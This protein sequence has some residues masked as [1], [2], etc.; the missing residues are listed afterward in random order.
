M[1]FKWFVAK[2]MHRCATYSSLVPTS[3]ANLAFAR[4]EDFVLSSG[5]FCEDLEENMSIDELL[6]IADVTEQDYKKALQISQRG[7]IV[8]LKREIRD[9]FINNYNPE[10]LLGWNGNMDI[11]LCFDPHAVV[12]YIADYYGK[13]ESGMTEFLKQAL[14]ENRNAATDKDRLH[15]L[16]QAYLTHRQIGACE[17]IYRIFPS[18]H[19]KDSNITTTFVAS[20]F[21]CNRSTFFKKVKSSHRQEESEDEDEELGLGLLRLSSFDELVVFRPSVEL[22]LL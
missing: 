12:T 22:L 15:A 18:L 13:D 14:R 19:M 5:V 11:Q 4:L 17:A 6:K 21:P 3:Y 2:R 1:P 16:K 10:W 7:K 20:G 8:I 9:R